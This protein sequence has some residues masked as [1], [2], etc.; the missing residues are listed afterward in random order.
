M[1][2]EPRVFA[3]TP[4]HNRRHHTERCLELLEK[5]SYSNIKVLVIDD[6]SNDGTSEMIVSRFPY[7]ELIGGTGNWFWNGSMRNGIERVLELSESDSD[8]VFVLNDDLEFGKDLIK[9]LV[10][11]IKTQPRSI[12]QAVG[13]WSDNRN[14]IQYAGRE[15]NWWTAKSRLLHKGEKLNMFEKNHTVRSDTLTGRG[16]L[17]PIRVF[18][19]VGN[20]DP[21]IT[22]RGDPEL[23]RRAAKAGWGLL[24]YFGAVVYSYPVRANGN[25]N[26]QESYRLKDFPKYYCDVRSSAHLPTIWRLSRSGTHSF[27]QAVVFFCCRVLCLSFH[28]L[29]YFWIGRKKNHV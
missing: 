23:P 1:G 26:E 17:F 7:V 6:G 27:F 15:V 2:D 14:V 5:Q 13:S 16:V 3:V 25:I 28:L 21:R 18:K 9:S 11:F 10:K 4:V 22:H 24:V 29:R 8:Y 20:Y 19:E 12:V